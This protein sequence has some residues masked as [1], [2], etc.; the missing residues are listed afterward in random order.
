VRRYGSAEEA[1]W[2]FLEMRVN[3]AGVKAID[4]EQPIVQASVRPVSPAFNNL[5]DI[6]SLRRVFDAVRARC[7]ED[8]FAV[9]AMY[10]I[11]GKSQRE[12]AKEVDAGKTTVLMW[13]RHVDTRVEQELS[14]RGMMRRR[15]ADLGAA[16]IVDVYEEP[17]EDGP[18][19]RG[20][21]QATRIVRVEVEE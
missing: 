9:W 2:D 12:I 6:E 5:S 1:V 16:P 19:M 11:G 17:D 20:P 15:K 18:A 14:D 8:R 4:Y 13:V 21:K 7:R 10:R 3:L